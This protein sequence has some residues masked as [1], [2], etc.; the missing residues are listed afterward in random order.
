MSA[1]SLLG[2][3]RGIDDARTLERVLS[4]M[5]VSIASTGSEPGNGPMFY[6]LKGSEGSGL[7]LEDFKTRIRTSE[8]FFTRI[9]RGVVKGSILQ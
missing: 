5:K 6:S 8:R 7:G 4:W 9:R 3:W 2:G 1:I